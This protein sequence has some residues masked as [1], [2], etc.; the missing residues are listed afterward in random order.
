[1]IK[2]GIIIS[3]NME[4]YYLLKY[5]TNIKFYN[6]INFKIYKGF[7]N[8]IKIIIFQTNIGKVNSTIGTT[9]L[10]EKF[11]VNMIINVGT[12]GSISKKI[13]IN[14]II[15]SKKTAYYDT[16]INFINN[17]KKHEL[18][19][20]NYFNLNIKLISCFEMCINKIKNKYKKGLIVSGDYF[21]D[22]KIAINNIKKKFPK[23]IA[24]DMESASISHVCYLFNKPCVI[25]RIVSDLSCDNSIKIFKKNV[26][27]ISL[28]ISNIINIFLKKYIYKNF[29]L[30]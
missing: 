30:L 7:W 17:F 6:F 20:S 2:I 10:I 14:N 22:N 27:N 29:N 9:L 16:N 28:K 15:L 26:N 1:M 21:I 11:K 18:N 4:V 5:L 8:N 23:A 12:S 13:K 25:L 3:I 24:I 19:N